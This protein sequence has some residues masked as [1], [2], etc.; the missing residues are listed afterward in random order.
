MALREADRVVI[1]P[2]YAAREINESG[3]SEASLAAA[4]RALGTPC[5]GATDFASAAELVLQSLDAG[6]TL[7]VKGAGDVGKLYPLLG[8]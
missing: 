3:V 1:A 8:D 6:D 2:I 7:L 4:V 5:E